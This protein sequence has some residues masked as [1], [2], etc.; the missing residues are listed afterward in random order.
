MKLTRL[1]SLLRFLTLVS[2]AL[3]GRAQ[4]LTVLVNFNG[5]NGTA[6]NA[7]IQG[8][9]GNF[10]GT[11]F[12]GGAVGPGTVFKMTPSGTLTTLYSFS[13]PDGGGP[14][15]PLSAGALLQG[16]DGNLYGTTFGGGGPA[17]AGTVFKIT[18]GG[19]LTTLYTFQ[20]DGDGYEPTGSVAQ[21]SDGTVYG[22]TMGN[23]GN[24]YSVTQAGGFNT[25]YRF[26][27]DGNTTGT[28]PMGGVIL[29]TDGNLY[30]TTS[31]G[32]LA[33]GMGEG[34]VFDLTLAGA[35]LVLH[36]FT[37]ASLGDGAWPNMLLQASDGNFYGSTLYG[38]PG[39][40]ACVSTPDASGCGTIFRLAPSGELTTLHVFTDGS[41]PDALIQGN[42][43]NI[44]GTTGTG[45][46]STVCKDGCG[47]VFRLSLGG[48]F[49]S[50]YAFNSTSVSAP[51]GIVQAKDGS[52]YGTATGQGTDNGVVFRL[53]L[54]SSGVNAPAVA[55][56]GIVN[57]ASFEAG[58]VS[59]SWITISGT[60]LS[61]T[62]DTWANSISNGVLPT[63]VGGVSV[64]IG[65]QSAYISY[66]SPTQ[67]NAIAPNVPSGQTQVTVSSG[68]ATSAPVTATIEAV[69]PAFFLWGNYAVATT[70]DYKLAVKNG[71]FPGT[72]TTPAAP[73][74]VIILWGTGFGP[75]SPAAPEGEETPSGTTYN[76]AGTVSATVGGKTAT[77][78]GAALAPGFA[79]L[80][81]VA[82][83]IPQLANGDYPVVATISGVSSPA[84]T[85]ITVQ[86]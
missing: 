41:A 84:T 65:G 58:V 86:Q 67:V 26:C 4:T 42:D 28:L 33:N 22:T 10:Y 83:H 9:D 52:L 50:L 40:S 25:V 78:Y 80:Y 59:G 81:Q 61:T 6:P 2:I 62:T 82:I 56:G 44:Y 30:G 79:G 13:G 7:I 14:G 49:T 43:G 55:T 8:T 69:Q 12:I 74:D 35:L 34:E 45:G 46:G 36:G 66:I 76:T 77:V 16:S 37:G 47:T 63:S 20:N 27:Q 21:G 68:G 3:A 15:G 57:A 73:G 19:A 1:I 29:G 48:D 71:T 11:T 85:L 53:S 5:A 70:Q 17:K 18:T 51:T 24:V 32:G 75:T 60:N 38:G 64:S 72:T 54:G 39:N 31:G 23:C